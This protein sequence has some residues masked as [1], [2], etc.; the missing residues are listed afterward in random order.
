[1]VPYVISFQLQKQQAHGPLRRWMNVPFMGKD[2]KGRLVSA[3]AWLHLVLIASA[4]VH[5]VWCIHSA[6][7]LSL[8][9]GTG[10]WTGS[11]SVLPAVQ[12]WGWWPALSVCSSTI[13]MGWLVGFFMACRSLA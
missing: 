10:I 3:S 13:G 9:L 4:C 11:A 1:M 2:Q 8:M 5:V 12:M 7:V 6:V